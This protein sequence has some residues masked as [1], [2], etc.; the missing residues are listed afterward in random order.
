M[1]RD[2]YFNFYCVLFFVVG[3]YVVRHD[4]QIKSICESAIFMVNYVCVLI[5]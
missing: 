4:N 2:V 5:F 1:K 3:V